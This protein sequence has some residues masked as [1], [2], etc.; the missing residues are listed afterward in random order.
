MSEDCADRRAGLKVRSIAA[1]ERHALRKSLFVIVR[2]MYDVWTR[3]A[4]ISVP[5][6]AVI[7]RKDI[8]KRANAQA[9]TRLYWC[10]GT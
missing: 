3:A 6:R 1:N 8:N 4:V 7:G 2:F 9:I 5:C 10:V